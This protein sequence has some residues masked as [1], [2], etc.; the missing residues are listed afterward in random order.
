MKNI[1][2]GILLTLVSFQGISQ[3]LIIRTNGDYIYCHIL[4]IDSVNVYLKLIKADNKIDTHISLDK[5]KEIIY[6]KDLNKITQTPDSIFYIKES[7]GYSY[8]H[9]GKLIYYKN[10]DALLSFNPNAYKSFKEYRD[11]KMIGSVFG[12]AGGFMVGL[13][14]GAAVSGKD[15]QWYIAGAGAF[16]IV[17]SI[18]ISI[19]ARK[20]LHEAIDIY[21]SGLQKTSMIKKEIIFGFNNEGLGI[22]FKF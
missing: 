9:K 21:N 15:P 10:I 11:N 8:H 3:D 19:G 7:S 2:A 14:L 16:L 6:K 18:P 22:C 12:F 4:K 1:F 5:V 17:L 20:N 13:Y